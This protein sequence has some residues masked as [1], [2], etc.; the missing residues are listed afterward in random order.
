MFSIAMF[1]TSRRHNVDGDGRKGA[2]AP[3]AAGGLAG[4]DAADVCYAAADDE[5][6]CEQGLADFHTAFSSRQLGKCD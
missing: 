5:H 1:M 3:G 4:A 2:E 6:A